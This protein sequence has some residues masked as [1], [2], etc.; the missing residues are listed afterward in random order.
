MELLKSV[1][2]EIEIY[3]QKL[4]DETEKRN[5]YKV[6]LEE[7]KSLISYILR[8]TDKH[9]KRSGVLQLN[10]YYGCQF[11]TQHE[12]MRLMLYTDQSE[13]LL[14]MIFYVSLGSF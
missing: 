12:L 8:N 14:I 11:V 7:Y 9:Q 6:S 2:S 4:Q 1:E 13:T 10:Q 5:K 3:E